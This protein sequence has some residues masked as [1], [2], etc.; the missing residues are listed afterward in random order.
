LHAEDSILP[1][2]R[3]RGQRIHYTLEGSGPLLV[4]QHGLL[5]SAEDWR[6]AGFAGAFAETFT[7]ACVDSLG[8]GLSDKPSDAALYRQAQR[9][10]DVVAV[11]DDIGAD[12]AHLLGYSMGGWIS[13]GVARFHPERLASLVIGG[14]DFV[15]GIQTVARSMGLPRFDFDM[16]LAAV[17]QM[18][19]EMAQR[20][21]PDALPGLRACFDALADLGDAKRAIAGLDVP[22]TLWNGVDDAYHEPMRRYAETNGFGFLSSPGDH[23]GAMTLHGVESAR[24]LTEM[25]LRR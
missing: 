8:H 25:I 5:S 1:Y 9:A 23:L 12:K 7:V 21:A 6:Q 16:L 17:S 13:V 19:P 10:A 24:A 20:I 14:W 11:I 4:L 3:N 15:D 18:A 2:A 22:V